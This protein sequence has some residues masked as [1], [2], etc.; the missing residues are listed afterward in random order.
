MFRFWDDRLVRRFSNA[1]V[2]A[3]PWP[4]SHMGRN[5]LR[6]PLAAVALAAMSAFAATGQAA[7]AV[8]AD[9][10]PGYPVST[11]ESDVR[12]WIAAHTSVR[13]GDI[14]VIA[15]GVVVALERVARA[16]DAAA[17]VR[18]TVHEELVDARLA[19]QAHIRSAR[20]EIE[21]GC[22][23]GLTRIAGQTK[24]TLPDLKGDAL[25]GGAAA[26]WTRSGDGTPM[27]RIAK[28]ACGEG[29]GTGSRPASSAE[30]PH[31]GAA[32]PSFEVL[33]GSYSTDANAH[34]AV[35]SLVR[36]FPEPM[37]GREAIVHKAIAKGRDYFLVTVGGFG[38]RADAGSF[39]KAVH[40]AP[41]DCLIRR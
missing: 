2:R 11:E 10:A 4:R 22:A 37:Q 39:C 8:R 33:L 35:A 40:A 27:Q 30:A 19:E 21:V 13:P 3:A 41:A 23:T 15:P 26:D 5:V 34:A 1:R 16:A 14:L 38:R 31:P 36:N 29:A 32:G 25:S 18:I 28:A 9:S 6:L 24:F 17:P 12:T 20:I 7:G